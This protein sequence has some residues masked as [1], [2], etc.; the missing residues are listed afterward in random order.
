MNNKEILKELEEI[1]KVIIQFKSKSK[2]YSPSH[3]FYKKNLK[4]LKLN[5]R[6]LVLKIQ[7]DEAYDK[8]RSIKDIYN[9]FSLFLKL[10]PPSSEKLNKLL[11]FIDMKVQELEIFGD[12]A[13][14]DERIYEENSP[15]DFHNDIR[16]I[17]RLAKKE[18]FIIE[19][20]I[21]EE[22]LEITLRGISNQ[23]DIKIL[24][25]SN[26]AKGNFVK[27]SNKFIS[28]HKGRFEARERE[29]VH[30]RG[31]FIDNNSGWVFGQSIKQGGK[32]PTYII[33]LKDSKKLEMVYQKIWNFAKKIK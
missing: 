19:P 4:E 26:N 5:V 32:K 25:N 33:K 30:D 20:Y 31:I 15:F 7:K 6:K 8:D 13:S 21:D 14:L 28:Q 27:I 11:D 3:R 29:N 17:L 16:D 10:E 2:K 22:I 23:I 1:K 18:I 9:L 24:S 12:D